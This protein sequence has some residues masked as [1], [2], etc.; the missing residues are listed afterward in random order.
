MA[1]DPLMTREC[2]L[3]PTFDFVYIPTLLMESNT[4]CFVYESFG[5]LLKPTVVSIESFRFPP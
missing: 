3:L 1:S 4:P 2:N 5:L